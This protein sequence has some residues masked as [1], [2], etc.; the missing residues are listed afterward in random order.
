MF[1]T[2]DRTGV[3]EFPFPKD[4]VFRALCEA[5]PLIKGMK[6]DRKDEL[7]SRAD[8][9][10]AM[11]AFSWGE[12]VSVAVTSAG[13]GSSTVGVSSGAKTIF[14]SATVHGKS[15]KNVAEII[16]ETSKILKAK[17][18]QWAAELAPSQ[19]QSAAT[20]ILGPISG[21]LAKLATLRDQGV[22]T[23]QEFQVVKGRLLS[24]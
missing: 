12:K 8:I 6:I 2:F 23:D 4:V 17:G 9:S 10:A 24:A 20:G 5:I 3:A 7:G 18:E 19:P 1:D 21:E 15:R 11:S 14:G 22:L 13:P 16:A